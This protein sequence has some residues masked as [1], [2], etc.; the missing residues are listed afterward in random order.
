MCYILYIKVIGVAFK[1][2][3]YEIVKNKK[4]KTN[5]W[6]CWVGIRKSKNIPLAYRYF[7]LIFA[8][9][10]CIST[11]TTS[12]HVIADSISGI[13]IAEFAYFVCAYPKMRKAY[14]AVISKLTGIFKK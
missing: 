9:L 1:I 2:R 13:L 5:I 8:I 10:V 11:L 7:S 6:L 3:R 4:I 12:Q 14:S